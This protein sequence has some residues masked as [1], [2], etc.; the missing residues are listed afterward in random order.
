MPPLTED[1]HHRLVATAHRLADAARGASLAHFRT[2]GLTADNKAEPGKFDPVTQAD[3]ETEAA[4]RAILAA[5]RPEDGVLG[6]E[7]EALAGS[8]GLTWVIDPIDGTRAYLIGAPTWGVLIAL[9]DGARPVIGVMDQPFVGERFWS[10]GRVARWERGGETRD[11][12]SRQG[13]S[14]SNALLCTTMPEV[15]TAEERLLFERVRDR[16]RLTRYGLDCTAYALLAAGHVDLVI[17]AGLHAFDVQALMPV[18]E[19]AGGVIT[20]WSGGDPQNGGRILAA[21]SR[22]LHAEAMALLAG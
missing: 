8:S 7:E 1:L 22:E 10:D 4:I 5:E 20:T 15:G 14:L 6:E 21:G 18:I 2:D 9:N 11:I 16:V 13:V 3:R 17:E 12:R 19:T